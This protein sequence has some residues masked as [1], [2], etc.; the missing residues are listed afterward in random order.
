MWGPVVV[1][2]T[3]LRVG[4][5]HRTLLGC[6]HMLFLVLAPFPFLF[7]VLSLSLSVCRV[8]GEA[9]DSRMGLGVGGELG[10]V[11]CML[12]FLLWGGVP[13]AAH[14][15]LVVLGVAVLAWLP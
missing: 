7:P 12:P 6:A 2:G 15:V 8:L 14:M 5:A 10:M 4:A 9:L 13:W 11:G 1:L 3:L